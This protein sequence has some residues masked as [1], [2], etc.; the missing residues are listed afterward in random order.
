[1]SGIAAPNAP[2][3]NRNSVVSSS[4]LARSS[5]IAWATPG[6]WILTATWRPSCSTARWTWP[7]D[8]AAMGSSLKSANTASIGRPS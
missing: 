7:M 8:A 3:V 5:W 2:A 1:M 4:V 6:Y